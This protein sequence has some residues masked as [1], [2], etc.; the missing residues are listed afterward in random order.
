M[1]RVWDIKKNK[2]GKQLEHDME[3]DLSRGC[4]STANSCILRGISQDPL[5]G[6]I[7]VRRRRGDGKGSP[8]ILYATLRSRRHRIQHQASP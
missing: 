5:S 4:R 3:R 6:R 2:T 8:G 7:G 1:F